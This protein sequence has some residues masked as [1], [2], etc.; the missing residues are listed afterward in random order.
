[1]GKT[2]DKISVVEKEMDIEG[3]MNLKKRISEKVI[4]NQM[5]IYVPTSTYDAHN[6]MYKH[7]YI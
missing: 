5:I 1:M 2:G 4:R 7:T 6:L 3:D